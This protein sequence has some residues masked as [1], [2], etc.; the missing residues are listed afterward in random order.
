MQPGEQSHAA[1]RD[2][3]GRLYG[4][5]VG[6]GDPDL[7]TVKARRLIEQS[8]VLAYP[9]AA[10]PSAKGVARS[11]A[12]PFFTDAHTLVPMV[13][14][15]TTGQTDH[16]GGYE[17]ALADFYDALNKRG[18]FDNGILLITGDHHAMTPIDPREYAKF[19]ERSFARIPL[20]V[21]GAVDMPRVVDAS[22][23]QSDFPAS[24]AHIMGVDYCRTPFNG[25]FLD[26]QPQPPRYVVQARG[27][28]RNRVDVYYDDRVASYE[29]N[30]DAS[31]WQGAPPPQADMVAA[32]IN[33]QRLRNASPVG[34]AP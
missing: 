33:A 31:G 23:Q 27:D 21:A 29:Q 28:D 7:M 16:P 2:G 14:P 24:L 25:I 12:E 34:K 30:G 17:G 1:A 22:F 5:G 19:G 3:V 15:V 20:I 10:N 4:V 8:P 26:P 18:F 9:I 6:P 32:W 13:Y 11:I